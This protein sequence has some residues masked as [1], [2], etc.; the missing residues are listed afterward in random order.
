MN[1]FYCRWN[2]LLLAC[3]I[4]ALREAFTE[5]LEKADADEDSKSVQDPVGVVTT[6]AVTAVVP[7]K[8]D[9]RRASI[10]NTVSYQTASN[11]VEKMENLLS[12]TKYINENK[13]V[14]SDIERIKKQGL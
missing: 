11:E 13:N 14:M 5:I 3:R 2:L 7:K 10:Q 1:S 6:A 12:S 8:A 4:D 9:N